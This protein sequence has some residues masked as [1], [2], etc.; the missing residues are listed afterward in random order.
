MRAVY[1]ASAQYADTIHLDGM[2]PIPGAAAR[3]PKA[4]S[5]PIQR[6]T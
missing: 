2:M 1:P 5:A 6:V 4:M 3:R